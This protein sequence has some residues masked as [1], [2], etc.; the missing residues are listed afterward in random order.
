MCPSKELEPHC[1]SL[2]ATCCLFMSALLELH[3]KI[4]YRCTLFNTCTARLH[5]PLLLFY[6]S[7]FNYPKSVN[8][9]TINTIQASLSV[10]G[11]G[12]SES[13]VATSLTAEG[14]RT[15]WITAWALFDAGWAFADDSVV[16]FCWITC[17][18]GRDEVSTKKKKEIIVFFLF[19]FIRCYVCAPAACNLVSYK[20]KSLLKHFSEC[21]DELLLYF[22][23]LWPGLSPVWIK[24]IDFDVLVP[25]YYSLTHEKCLYIILHQ[26]ST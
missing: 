5:H 17:L 1:E 23:V 9:F 8:S 16:Q 21:T 12:V 10:G 19:F 6:S 15:L 25:D 3:H 4:G 7:L 13:A 2:F 18:E 14:R 22:P 20:W 24:Q 11:G 26:L